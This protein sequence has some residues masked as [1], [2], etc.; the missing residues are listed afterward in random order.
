MR[1]TGVGRG[2]LTLAGVMGLALAAGV[3]AQPKFITIASARP[4]GSWYITGAGWAEFLNKYVPGVE[5]KVEQSGGGVQNNKLVSD[6]KAEFA[7]SV[8]RLT[9]QALAGEGPFKE[10]LPNIRVLISNWTIGVLQFAALERSGIK[11]VCDLKGK[12]VTLGPAGG[13]GI[14]AALA[15]FQGCGFG[16]TEVTASFMAYEQGKEALVDGHVDAFLSYAAVPVPA[17]KSL[18]ATPGTR[19]R[20]LS[21]PEDKI[22]A[23]VKANPGYVRYVVPA[24]AYGREADAVTIGAPNVFIVNKDLPEDFV[25]RVT[26]VMMEHLEEFKRIHPTHADMTREASAEPVAELPFHPGASRY[27]K[28]AGLMK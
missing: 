10:Q 12:R 16:Q 24:K 27:Y 1:R 6:G 11:T 21:L 22:Q 19:W 3:A 4:G 28:E 5:A 25:Y 23:V 17:L 8:A 7:P 13:G 14:P 18:E 15:V 26:K 2:A 20:L 9:A